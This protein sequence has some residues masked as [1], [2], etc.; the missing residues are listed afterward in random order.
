M[1]LKTLLVSLIFAAAA[2]VS[3]VAWASPLTFNVD[4]VISNSSDQ[5]VE[6]PAVSFLVDITNPAGDCV[7]FRE[8]FVIA[9]TGSGGYFSIVVGK[10]ANQIPTGATLDKVFSNQASSIPGQGASCPYVPTPTD[11]R[12]VLISFND[13]SGTQTFSAQEI[14]SVPVAIEAH[15]A[16]KVGDYSSK[17]IIKVDAAVSQMT[18]PNNALNQAQ[19]D[20]FWKLILGTSTTYLKTIPTLGG[21][22]SGTLTAVNVDKLKGYTLAAPAGAADNGKVLS[23]NAG[24]GWTLQ[25]PS[26]PSDSTYA[27]KGLIQFDTDAATS[28][29][30]YTSAGVAKVNTGTAAN[31]IVQLNGAAKL[32]AVDGSLLTNIAIPAN[33]ITSANILDGTIANADI[34]ASAAIAWSKITSPTTLSG[35]AITDAVTNAGG[36]PSLASGTIAVRPAASTAGRIYY[37]TDT[38]QQFIDTGVTWNQ[39]NTNAADLSG[40]VSTSS[41][42]TGLSTIGSNNQILGMNNGASGLEYKSITAGSGVSITHGANTITIDATGSGGTVTNVTGS[43]PISVA[44]GTTTPVISIASGTSTG[45]ALRWDGS[46][47]QAGHIAMTDL[48]SN[49]TGAAMFSTSCGANQTLTYNSVGDIMS[50]EN[51]AIDANQIIAGTLP[52][53]RG[54]TGTTSLTVNGVV[55]GNGSSALQTVSPGSAGNIL[56]SDGTT[57]LSQTNLAFIKNGNNFGADA[58]IGLNSAN[59]L[60]IETNGTTRMT[61]SAGGNVGIGNTNPNTTLDITGGM[62][63]R[64]VAAASAPPASN[65]GKI[66][67]DSTQNKFKVSE[68]NGAF[69]DLVNPGAATQWTTNASD[70]HYS[71]GNVGI[72]TATP[73]ELLEVNGVSKASYFRAT[74]SGYGLYQSDGTTTLVTYMGSGYGVIGT[75]SNS[76]LALEVNSSEKMTLLPNGNVGV[77]TASPMVS[78]DV[79]SKTDSIRLPAGSSGQ[80]PASPTNGDIRYNSTLGTIEGYLSNA[81]TALNS[82]VVGRVDITSTPY[83]INSSQ[84]GVF[85]SYN[86]AVAGVINLPQLSILPDGWQ[87][88][89]MRKVPF[90]LAITPFGSDGFANGISVFDMQANNL[91]SVTLTKNGNNWTLTNQTLDCIVGKACWGSGNIY[92]GIYN[93]KQYFTTPGGCTNST[94]PTCSGGT[95]SNQLPWASSSPEATTTLGLLNRVDGQSQSATLA[96]Y[97]TAAAAQFCENMNYGSYTDWYLPAAQE[98]NLLYTS[99]QTVGGFNFWGNYWSST[100]NANMVAWSYDFVNGKLNNAIAKNTSSSNF[101]RCVRRF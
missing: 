95:D 94:T 31:Q 27:A 22:V 10:T 46:V 92:V 72:G 91:Q 15:Q 23:F 96:A 6:A 98:L 55:L 25:T 47:W 74:N 68:N 9:M 82:A 77:G 66:Y 65:E 1:S 21:D 41:G 88:T 76:K 90:P 7:L 51:I 42:G 48:R 57:W 14:Q 52:V 69:V 43:S 37:A 26:S 35:Y 49:V 86:Y 44:T 79:S 11:A 50:C 5:A 58:T 87:I 4:G 75:E 12:K 59:N 63:Y 29:M 3:P 83:T 61:I 40:T 24:S 78:L 101:V 33:A 85:F 80:R 45:Q 17:E 73:S 32:P 97:A 34:S 67:F 8:S 84:P 100:E 18:N 64:G 13:G 2:W 56:T 20:E 38:K 30:T 62:T 89:I 71:S 53:T 16:A 60:G 81:W 99:S 19:Y 28:G 70:I 36:V 39:L 54:G 93:G